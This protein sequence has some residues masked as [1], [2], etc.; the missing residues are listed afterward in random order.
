M[1]QVIKVMLAIKKNLFTSTDIFISFEDVVQCQYIHFMATSQ[2]VQRTSPS[3]LHLKSQAAQGPLYPL[4]KF[5]AS[6]W[7]QIIKEWVS[8]SKSVMSNSLQLHELYSPSNYLGQNNG[9]GSLSLLQGI[10][11]TQGSNPD[12]PYC[13]QI[14]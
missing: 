2:K 7:T 6:L 11:P 10:F 1:S 14:L 4:W 9:V 5:F 12:F 13:R 8:E 3:G